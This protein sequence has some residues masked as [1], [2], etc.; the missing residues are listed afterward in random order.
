M[1]LTGV[2]WLLAIGLVIVGI[3]GL[4]L[5]A[6]PGAPLLFLGLVIAAWADNFVY[7]DNQ[8]LVVLAVLAALTY[9]VDIVAGAL[10]AR[11]FG[12]SRWAI[13]GATVGAL[14]GLFFGLAGIILGPFLGALAAELLHSRNLAIAGRSGVGATLG[15]LAGALAKLAIAFSMLGLFAYARFSGG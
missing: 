12:A 6:L 10:G 1:L 5:P 4:A 8:M 3:A 2:L 7:I 9:A 11:R 13:V 15:M 14:V